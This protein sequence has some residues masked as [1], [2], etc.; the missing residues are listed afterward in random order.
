MFVCID[1]YMY[2]CTFVNIYTLGMYV[3]MYE[4]LN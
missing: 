2:V 4:Y 3:C 1:L